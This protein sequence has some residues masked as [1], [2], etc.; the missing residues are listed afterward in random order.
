[1]NRLILLVLCASIG[2]SGLRAAPTPA[3]RELVLDKRF[4]NLPV[5]HRAPKQRVKLL[6]EGQVAR[7]FEIELALGEPDFWVFLDLAPFQGKRAL[8][9]ADA[10]PA[11]S[12]ALSAI[13][14]S[15]QIKGAENLYH[16][17]LRP[18]FHFSSRRGWNN[19]PNGLVYYQG[20]Y[21]LFYQHNP[22][23]WDWGSMHWGHAVSPDMVH[24]QELPIALYPRQ[25]GD[26]V[27]SG[28]AV[29]DRANTAGF[30]TGKEAPLVAAFTSTGRGECIV[31]SNDRGRTWTELSGNPVVRHQ[32]R[33]P[34]LL[35]HRPTKRWVMAVYD[36]L[37]GKRW[38]AFHTSADLKQWK[39]ENRI[40]GFYECPD[41]FE[42]PVDGKPAQKL[43]VLTAAS[44][45]YR[46]GTFDGRQFTPQTPMLPGHRGNAFYAAQ[47]Y[48]DIPTRDGRR[49]QIGWARI[50][51]PDMPFNQ[52]M[53]FPC[54]L[55][56]RSTA[57][58]PRLCFQP[59][60]ELERF[61][62][63]RHVWSRVTLA[64]GTNALAG[65]QGDLFDLR[66]QFSVGSTGE[67]RLVVRG[68][69]VTYGVAKQELVCADRRNPL[70]PV[71][72]KVRL[73][74][75]VDCT[76]LE[77]FGNDG[78]LYMPM[79]AK[80]APDDPSLVLTVSDATVHF[81]SLE[82]NELRSIWP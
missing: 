4:L 14:L 59:V 46:L 52:M 64:P 10:L 11:D 35:W 60:K 22:Y 55:T 38:I 1:M 80:F 47:T 17:A 45:E 65:I 51:T 6:V 3:A 61:H 18:Q 50:A 76:S 44:S 41:L 68:M 20:E 28:S 79:A 72:G 5:R 16:E 53:A 48:S 49:I 21:H 9:Q 37:D 74:V 57:A 39:F 70:P 36:E 2:F 75:L 7:E 30:Q 32:G 78:L 69:P 31:F 15:D 71:N 73:Q 62:A 26:W 34:R 19:D 56:L 67:V 40:E 13:E 63:V 27:F 29:V 12:A 23:G 42:L 54:E 77:I 66:A 25:F 43:W 82:V 33:D 24:W 8:L 81:D 58:G